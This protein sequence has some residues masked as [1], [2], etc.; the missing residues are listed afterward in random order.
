MRSVMIKLHTFFTSFL[1]ILPSIIS[2]NPSN[3]DRSCPGGE[4]NLAP[5]PF[6]FSS[7]CQIQL[8][9]TSH[10]TVFINEFPVQDITPDA[11]LLSLPATCGRTVD[12][13]S[14]LYGE[15]YAPTSANN[16]LMHNCKE[17]TEN[18]VI[19]MTMLRTQLE[20]TACSTVDRDGTHVGNV[21][22][23]TGDVS[24]MFFD[25]ENV[26]RMGCRFLFSG[27]V[28][29]M[30]G[31]RQAS[32]D[33][34]VFKLGWWI[35]GT[36]NCSGDADCTKIVSPSDGSDGHRCTCK[37]GF[38]GDGYEAG[39]GCRKVEEGFKLSIVVILVI[40]IVSFSMN[41]V[42]FPTSLMNQGT[43]HMLLI[44][45]LTML[46]TSYAGFSCGIAGIMILLCVILYRK[47]RLR[48]TQK[49]ANHQ[50]EMFVRNYGTISLKRYKYLE[51]KKMTNSFQVKLGQG[52]YG[53]V[54]KG[55]LP[56]GHL[57]AVKLLG[58]ATGDGEDFI[59]EVASISR[60]SHVNI[61]T[62]LG[63][64]IEGKKR[65]LMYEFMPNGSLDKFLRGDDTHLDWNTLFLIAKGIAK[66]L[67]YLHQGCNTRIVHFDIKPHNI[68]LDEEFVPKISDFGLAKPCK[69][70]K[71][72]VS[73][74]G[75][76]GTVGYMAPEVYFKNLGGASHKSDVYSYGMMVLEMTGTH[77]NINATMTSTSEAYFPD[78]IYKQIEDGE[79]LGVE[80][81]TSK[82]EEELA[83]KMVMTSL[84]CI[85]FY[86]S[87]RPSI[88]KVVE[89]LEGS[90]QSL[91][92]PPRRF[93]SSPR[94]LGQDTPPSATHS[95]TSERALT[96]Q[97]ADEGISS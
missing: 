60:T 74:V 4:F 29:E 90:S 64:C 46:H 88:S 91:Q 83:R 50:I 80:G 87:D 35:K 37:R 70:K 61:V 86:P 94:R 33:M 17:K 18:C 38:V 62:L 55:Q 9:C 66:G 49:I 5:Y 28:S 40:C 56:D 30:V 48:E 8:N 2:Q 95:S 39:S 12:T 73:V 69:R 63:F 44:F 72:T 1:F 26:T 3:C 13:I 10:G 31:D 24:R 22:C 81:V 76:R 6:G 15:N 92:V 11:L 14:H 52:G 68:L 23:Y 32:M 77:K 79:N 96:I 84:W 97:V 58:E 59:N 75:A 89:M 45:N 82:E 7:G 78:W 51:I 27:V 47:K 54:Y 34:Q 85:Q 25:Y 67:E 36:C 41:R 21:S 19:P 93:W 42:A 57:V 65:A 16:V 43:K 53:S 20:I 71:S